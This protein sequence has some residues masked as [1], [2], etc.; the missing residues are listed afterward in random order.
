MR[1]A[2]GRRL[3]PAPRFHESHRTLHLANDLFLLIDTLLQRRRRLSGDLGVASCVFGNLASLFGDPPRS[4]GFF[5]QLVRFNAP[6]FLEIAALLG[7]D[8]V[9]FLAI[10]F[11]FVAPPQFFCRPAFALG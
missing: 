7:E 3:L 9:G 4:L 8:A 11:C 6:P 1:R 5:A 2:L 10:P